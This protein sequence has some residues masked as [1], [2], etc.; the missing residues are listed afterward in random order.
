MTASVETVRPTP[1]GVNHPTF[2]AAPFN[3]GLSIPRLY[4]YH[5]EN[6]PNHP[7]FA[8]A[9][10]ATNEVHDVTFADMWK[11]ICTVSDIVLE[12]Y[13][14]SPTKAEDGSR[15]VIGVLAVSD[16]LSYINLE[17]AVMALGYIVL[18]LSPR[19]SSIVTAHLLEKTG[20]RQ[21]YVSTDDA[22]QNL[23][24]ASV[25]LLAHKGIKVDVVPMVTPDDWSK[26]AKGTG[27]AAMKDIADTDV[28]II[29]HSSGT[30]AFPKSIP[31]T[32]RSLVNLTNIPC[33]GEVD[34]AGKRI[35]AHTNPISHAMGLAA[36]M[37]PLTSGATFSFYPPVLPPP[38]PTPA[39]FLAA[40]TA[41]KCDIV[42]CIPVF[43][44]AWARDPANIPLLKALDCIVFS[45]APV[46]KPIG[47]MLA[48]S[49][50]T[51]HPFWGSTEVGPATM[52]IPR[53]PPAVD[54]WEYFK[55]SHHITFHLAP[56]KGLENIYEPIMIPTE[57][58]FPNA[59]NSEL[60]GKAVFAVGDLL[61]RHPTD[62]ERYRVF[63]RKDDQIVLSTAENVN[64]V[65]I[66]GVLVQDPNI[67]SAIMFGQQRIQMGV[68][69]EPPSHISIP[70]G[71]AQKLEEFKD[72]IWPTIEK[73][74][75]VSPA[76]ARIQRDMILV[77]SPEKPLEHTPKGTPR[78]GVCIKLYADEIEQLYAKQEEGENV[79]Q[80]EI[81]DRV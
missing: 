6:S 35:A 68:L 65:P 34:L 78:R 18:P 23:A 66:E 69:I 1:Q 3:H 22:M 39:N 4:E 31:I 58:C 73:A 60:D 2:K 20:V 76:F 38:V 67:A 24:R 45:G 40:W 62:P 74:N 46:S 57:R 53:D 33:F 47:D 27:K 9:D 79:Q 75:A 77:T 16:A 21:L 17:V 44:E 36:L 63:G 70:T 59:L 25:E 51:L 56:Q 43:I 81:V 13:E 49:G 11:S 64:P 5:A 15:P 71:D 10:P 48:K 50:V 32:R 28:T 61:E 37:W 7:A 26:P 54:E 12:R 30:T 72:L 41:C 19:N 42:F 14:N 8:Y 80:R 55:F 52:F 29:M